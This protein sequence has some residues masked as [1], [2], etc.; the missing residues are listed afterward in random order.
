MIVVATDGSDE[1]LA[2]MRTALDLAAHGGDELLVVAA[3]RELHATLGIP[4]GCEE[5]L[6]W[7]REAADVTA[8]LA[9]KVGLEPC[10][11][12][13]HGLPGPE[14]CAAAEAHGARL[15]VMGSRGLGPFAGAVLGS[16][17][18]YVLRHAPCSVLLVRSAEGWD[19]GARISAV[20]ALTPPADPPRRNTLR[21][22]RSPISVRPD[23]GLAP[24]ARRS[25]YSNKGV[26]NECPRCNQRLRPDRT[27]LPPRRRRARSADRHRGG[28]RCGRSDGHGDASPTR[29]RLRPLSRPRHGATTES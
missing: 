7:A 21:L 29:F 19:R 15:I 12:I 25:R 18:S 1:A 17:S 14:I 22:S 13:R 26:E 6:E 20:Q 23:S 28:Q 4:A 10:V 5:E 16:V 24:L 2:A 8:V 27:R 11:S 9:D 3:W